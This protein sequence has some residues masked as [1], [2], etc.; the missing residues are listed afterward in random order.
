[1]RVKESHFDIAIIGAGPAGT[2]AALALKESGLKVALIDKSSFPRDKVCG[3]AIGGRVKKVLGEIKSEFPNELK[4]YPQK[5]IS[6]GWKLFAPNGKTIEVNF[7]NPGYVS[8]RIDFD[9]WLFSK[10]RGQKNLEIINSGISDLHSDENG[11]EIITDNNEKVNATL[12]IGCDGAHSIVAKKLAGFKVDHR[13]Y[14]GAVRA[15]YQDIE[16]TANSEM[17]EIHLVNGFLP[18]YFW[19]FPL[20][21][22]LCNVG[23]GML[24]SDIKERRIDLKVALKE[25]IQSSSS[26]KGRFRNARLVDDVTGFGLPLGGIARNISGHRYMLCG[27][28]A[29]LIDPLTGEGIGNAMLSGMYA[30]KKAIKCF[31]KNSFSAHEMKGYDEAVYNKL[32]P[33]LKKNLFMQRAFNRPWLINLLVNVAIASPGLKNWFAK[34]L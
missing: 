19:I 6:S 29:S 24:S 20:Y 11:I 5:N 16:G 32:L 15:Y 25:I 18:G 31:E 7:V 28:A 14:S 4:N 3:D 10:V 13:H 12:V 8:R 34:K 27:D 2:T 9:D 26:L 17:L 30:A 21:D 22:N 23:F 33:E 1:L